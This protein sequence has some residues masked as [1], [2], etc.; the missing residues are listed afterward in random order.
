MK[1]NETTNE[2]I[3]VDVKVNCEEL[4]QLIM[5]IERAN[6]LADELAQKLRS[7]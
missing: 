2:S 5:K 7:L 6:S 3:A 4:D 1:E